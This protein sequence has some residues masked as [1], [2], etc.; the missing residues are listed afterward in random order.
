MVARLAMR[1]G[2]RWAMA[3]L[4]LLLAALAG[5]CCRSDYS[6]SG[7]PEKLVT[8]ALFLRIGEPQGVKLAHLSG[9]GGSTTHCDEQHRQYSVTITSGTAG[10]YASRLRQEVEKLILDSGKTVYGTESVLREELRDFALRY[11]DDQRRGMFRLY[12]ADISTNSFRLIVL[13]YEHPSGA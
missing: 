7:L 9:G 6:S 11:A 13:C 10:E 1:A 5:G 4:L 12:T 3:A 2:S 8:D